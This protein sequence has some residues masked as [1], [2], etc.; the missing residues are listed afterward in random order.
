MFMEVSR[1]V[2]SGKGGSGKAG[3]Q[4]ASRAPSLPT[5]P[6]PVGLVRWS[7]A[8]SARRRPP[9]G[10]A[11]GSPPPRCLP[12]GSLQTRAN[13]SVGRAPKGRRL[14][15]P[16]C[17]GVA[18]EQTE[19]WP[20]PRCGRLAAGPAEKPPPSGRGRDAGSALPSALPP[21]RERVSAQPAGAAPS[22]QSPRQAADKRKSRRTPA[23]CDSVPHRSLQ[24]KRLKQPTRTRWQRSISIL[25]KHKVSPWSV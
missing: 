22:A 5:G 11:P 14:G 17:T 13:G 3:W 1:V 25:L 23:C 19:A 8:E 6:R 15:P 18:A 16:F 2:R 7:C 21:R 9:L 24:S 12:P 4:A 10:R 20:A